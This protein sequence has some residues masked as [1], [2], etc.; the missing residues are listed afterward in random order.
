MD[1]NQE[2]SHLELP[3]QKKESV[4]APVIE[5][6]RAKSPI[7]LNGIATKSNEP[8]S[9]NFGKIN[10]Q[11]VDNRV[12]TFDNST[13][14][15][16]VYKPLSNGDTV[17][18]YPTYVPRIDNNE[19]LASQQ[20]T[21][22]KWA[23][24]TQKFLGKT[25]NAVVGGTVGI[26]Y[27]A[28]S[29]I[30]DGNFSAL[31]DNKFSNW[32]NDLDVKMNYQLP[33][34][35]TKQEEQAGVFGQLGTANFWADK[36][37]GGLSFTAGAI[38]S[39][40]IWG[41][42]TG[43]TSLATA[44][45]RLG[46]K[47]SGLARTGKWGV[48][49]LGEG[50]LLTAVARNK[51]IYRDAVA[52]GKVG[53]IASIAG[54]TMRS[55]GYEASVESLQY[56]KEAEENF[57]R[58][59]T[60]LNGREPEAEDIAKFERENES[61]A[62]T[63]F[64]SN[65]AIVGSSN[66]IGL[67]HVLN[68]KNPV[69][70]GIGDFINKKAF[71]YGI[72]SATKEVTKGTTKQ[73][74]AR[75]AFD[76]VLK[77]SFTEG[78]FEEGLQGVTNKT[79]NRWIEHT[80]NPKYTNENFDQVES[81]SKSMAEQYGSEEG[82]K[83]N[84]LGM[85]I[86]I[87]GG[88][89]NVRGAQKAKSNELE[90][91]ASMNR[92]YNQS[93]LQ[94]MILP[95]R[96]QM[97]NR[98]AGFSED[99]LSEENK[100]NLIKSHNAR[101]G[102]ITA[103]V[104]GKL[105]VGE[106]I[107]DMTKD[108]AT[109]LDA[110][111]PEQ[112]A[113]NGVEA[114][115]IDTVKAEQL[116]EF[117]DV[118]QSWKTN[119][120]YVQYMVGSKIVGEQDL[121]DTKLEGIFG[122]FSKNAQIVEALAYQITIGQN[123]LKGMQDIQGIYSR[124]LGAENA[125]VLKVVEKL[126]AE[127][128]EQAKKRNALVQVRF[129][130]GVK[131]QAILDKIDKLNKAPRETQATDTHKKQ[132]L[133]ASTALIE[134]ETKVQESEQQL[135]AIVTELN[136]TKTYQGEVSGISLAT[137]MITVEDLISLKDNVS[138][139]EGIIEQQ[140]QLNPQKAKYLEDLGSEYNQANDIF[141]QSLATQKA[142]MSTDKFEIKN[143]D[144]W[145]SRFFK[146]NG[147]MAQPT[148]E[149]FQEAINTYN[150]FQKN[151]IA[152]LLTDKVEETT[153][154]E[155][156]VEAG[157]V[158]QES[159]QQ[160]ADKKD[161]DL[162][163]TERE[164][165]EKNKDVIDAL[166]AENNKKTKPKSQ[167][168]INQEKIDE[169]EAERAQKLAEVQPIVVTESVTNNSVR[170]TELKEGDKFTFNGKEY[171][172]KALNEALNTGVEKVIDNIET[173]E[174]RTITNPNTLSKLPLVWF[175]ETTTVTKSDIERRRQ[176]NDFLGKEILKK[177]GFEN[178]N[179]L[180]NGSV[181]GGQDGWKIRFN[182][183]NPKT[184]DS[185]YDGKGKDTLLNEDYNSRAETLIN[186]LLDY[187]G[188]SDKAD[189]KNLQ[190]HYVIEDKD[191]SKREPFK[192][193]QGGEIGESD[194]TI[195]IGSADDVIKFI[196]DIRTKY[197]NILELLHSGNQS[198]DI[199]IDDVF[200]GRIE[201]RK[202]GF[203]GYH[204]P[205]NLN[206]VVGSDDFTFNFNNIRVN[207]SYTGSSLSDIR[208]IVEGSNK[209]YN[210]VF[211]ENLKKDFPELYKNIRNIIG[212]QLYGNYLQ[213]SDN[214]F[215]KLTTV[216]ETNA[217]YNA[218]IEALEQPSTTQTEVT[219]QAEIDKINREY[220][221]KIEA[222]RP[223]PQDKI[224][225]YK[226]RI[227]DML[228]GIYADLV[229]D[230]VDEVASKRPTQ[231]EIEEYRELRKANK[232]NSKRGKE[233]T[234][235]LKNWK[236]MSTLTDDGYISIVDLLDNIAQQETE[237]EKKTTK[238]EVTDQDIKEVVEDVM[239][240]GSESTD[241]KEVLNNSAE[242]VVAKIS[243]DKTKIEFSHLKA[244]NVVEQIGKDFKIKRKKGLVYEYIDNSNI[245]NIQI[246]DVIEIDNMS[247][248]MVENYRL[249]FDYEQV[250]NRAP[251]LNLYVEESQTYLGFTSIYSVFGD[252]MIKTPSQFGENNI[253]REAS[254]KVKKGDVLTLHVKDT[255]NW[256]KS[257]KGKT[258]QEFK[259]YAKDGE[260]N[261]VAVLKSGN[262]K[263]GAE[264]DPKY[265]SIRRSA[266][267]NWEE[268]GRPDEMNLGITIKV[269]EA[270]LTAPELLF[271]DG[272][273]VD[274]EI[275]KE[276]VEN[277]VIGKGFIENGKLTIDKTSEFNETEVSTVYLGRLTKKNPNMK[278][279]IVVFKVGGHIVA[280]PITM[281]KKASPIEFDALLQGTSQEMVKAVNQ[282][283]ID[284]NIPT[285]KLSFSDIA[286]DY[287]GEVVLSDVAERTKKAF[288]NRTTFTTAE[289]LA[290]DEYDATNL[291][292]D[293]T[294]RIALADVDRTFS[295]PKIVLD[296]DSKDVKQS[297]LTNEQKE[298]NLDAKAAALQSK[299]YDAVYG[300]NWDDIFK[301]TTSNQFAPIII[302]GYMDNGKAVIPSRAEGR[303]KFKYQDKDKVDWTIQ[304]R[305]KKVLDKALAEIFDITTMKIKASKAEKIQL[306]AP[307]IKEMTDY[308]IER[309][310]LLKQMSPKPEDVQ[311]GSEK[312][313]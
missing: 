49:A 220:N 72:N 34:Y 221:A 227:E 232:E 209:G 281:T 14:F 132:I 279:P 52:F 51:S 2:Y 292:E 89:V 286:L 243:K 103:M 179:R 40:G 177:L 100:G 87:A 124:E 122:S 66:L 65:M 27:G 242:P 229:Q 31:Y 78:L 173:E 190:K 28:G 169:L 203:S 10:S 159:L 137:D 230:T 185:Y 288:E 306:G 276:E 3:T 141:L 257:E 91:E 83:E 308:L 115:Q 39:E 43:G 301:S 195:Y 5:D 129:N 198:T 69:N 165:Y 207:I 166:R 172:V 18:M 291:A 267:E 7:G 250:K 270:L 193:L 138:K 113:E 47:L 191:G 235:I 244:K 272:K 112:W 201:G 6:L 30:S 109:A 188:S 247:F 29:A 300:K 200:K 57:Y 187:F 259:I 277:I 80:Y 239:T 241:R 118:A 194:F 32:M 213:G 157:E 135:Q 130:A 21:G 105:T 253:N 158:S 79:A 140:R 84:I 261:I 192:H 86:G 171:T 25:V 199:K 155:K 76:Y 254:F 222:L 15:L 102:A 246:G 210:G 22:E 128:P 99:A 164:V 182:I 50:A 96:I 151:T 290:S 1:N 125:R 97:A 147:K 302:D 176:E 154:L 181:K 236:L 98:I 60:E 19:L 215:L 149:W 17:A 117:Q 150:D 278:L 134:A 265:E 287:R 75:N 90:F 11:G 311:N 23:N 20:S 82:W 174:G 168:Q 249:S 252:K 266:F 71:G 161:E 145:L 224:A 234:K 264:V 64:A 12:Q 81:F 16:D 202:I 45:T 119:K 146:R 95:S 9:V 163:K 206:K 256:N 48:E 262:P 297:K 35:Y 37:L 148:K 212:F 61:T 162:N 42:A 225:E 63:V 131:R 268:A 285:E 178:E 255:D 160:I 46:A 121:E 26:V 216:S 13:P 218:E 282:A 127:K 8:F 38:I 312:I 294:I 56:K 263:F 41:W 152:P 4:I 305:D 251:Q 59:F 284:N 309:E 77:P 248:E 144:G 313:C 295:A 170:A 226:K 68:I 307:L 62:N 156:E 93:T 280:F 33:N 70:L 139:F 58:N 142:L 293:A 108:M 111:T 240:Q 24:G 110:L 205:T 94:S 214:E 73:I 196:S 44:G 197:P 107:K 298:V 211:D 299:L 238:D 231:A 143:I 136:A 289:Q 245:D 258:E 36:F 223:T 116:A 175:L 53:E 184:G 104:N 204:V 54:R 219:N 67:G 269:S 271:E 283:I 189:S 260:G 120:Q 183:K 208:I 133:D 167:E 310:E 273:L 186:F 153:N 123:S 274:G 55:A 233:L 85:I 101:I 88:T 106:S 126:S 217:K 304:R 74:F 228:K 92:T 296:L 237:I 275:T 303:G 180:P 114:D